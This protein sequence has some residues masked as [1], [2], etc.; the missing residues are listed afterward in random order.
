MKNY[1]YTNA[2]VSFDRAIGNLTEALAYEAYELPSELSGIF[3]IDMT[4]GFSI[5]LGDLLLLLDPLL[6][7]EYAYASTYEAIWEIVDHMNTEDLGVELTYIDAE[8]HI[9]DANVSALFTL[10]NGTIAQ[11]RLDDFRNKTSQNDY[12][13]FTSMAENFDSLLT[14]DFKPLLFGEI[15]LDMSLVYSGFVN[16]M[17]HFY[18]LPDIPLATTYI[19]IAD[20]TMDIIVGKVPAELLFAVDYFDSWKTAMLNI[21]AVIEGAPDDISGRISDL[22]TAI[23][24]K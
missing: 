6:K 10:N 12:G 19:V 24:E 11:T 14:N 5:L 9:L 15:T 3:S 18:Y 22:F 4:D 17:K 8:P 16:S 23:D 13:P 21:R 2:I 20:T 7:E 1:S